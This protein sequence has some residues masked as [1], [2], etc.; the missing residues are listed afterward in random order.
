MKW[1]RTSIL[2]SC[3]SVPTRPL[4][5]VTRLHG[6]RRIEI[7]HHL[8]GS[9]I[10]PWRRNRLYGSDPTLPSIYGNIYHDSNTRRDISGLLGIHALVLDILTVQFAIY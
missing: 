1:C 7:L 6:Y 10:L 5:R 4:D 3:Q 8:G 2:F 9:D